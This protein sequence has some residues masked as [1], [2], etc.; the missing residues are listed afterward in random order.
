MV[1]LCVSM[2]LFEQERAA[3]EELAA[4]SAAQQQHVR[5]PP[6]ARGE[7]TGEGGGTHKG[8]Q[9]VDAAPDHVLV[10]LAQRGHHADDAEGDRVE[11]GDARQRALVRRQ[12]RRNAAETFG[13][14][15]S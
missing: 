1:C 13:S 6:L 4:V 10:L 15:I 11:Q 14:G 7:A 5:M 8:W 2:R 12:T 9:D 3:A